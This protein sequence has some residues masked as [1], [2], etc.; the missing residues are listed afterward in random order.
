MK[1]IF[2]FFLKI[3]DVYIIEISIWGWLFV[4]VIINIFIFFVDKIFFD[5]YKNIFCGIISIFLWWCLVMFFMNKILVFNYY[6]FIS[7]I[8]E[9]NNIWW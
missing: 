2:E 1:I 5:G 6:L 9:I 8:N 4:M 3:N 7:S